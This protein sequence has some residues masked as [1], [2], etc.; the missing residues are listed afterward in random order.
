MCGYSTPYLSVRGPEE[1]RW[2]QRHQAASPIDQRN[3]DQADQPPF[4]RPYPRNRARTLG[5]AQRPHL[6]DLRAT[7]Q[8]RGD[9]RGQVEGPVLVVVEHHAAQLT[10]LLVYGH[11]LAVDVAVG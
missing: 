5:L 4:A 10:A 11:T 2:I 6:D 3:F 9:R 7:D 8:P 1:H